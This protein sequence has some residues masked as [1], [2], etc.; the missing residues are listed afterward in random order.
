MKPKVNTEKSTVNMIPIF[1]C[2]MCGKKFGIRCEYNPNEDEAE[3]AINNIVLSHVDR[4]KRKYKMFEHEY[5]KCSDGS[6]G[7][8]D[9]LGFL[10][11][12]NESETENT[13]DT[14]ENE[15]ENNGE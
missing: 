13:D 14:K 5:H 9:F 2:R 12:E 8:S 4:K 15:V 10:R 7:Y 6:L 11:E 3:D 1:R